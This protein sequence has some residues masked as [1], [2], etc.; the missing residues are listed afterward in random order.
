[1]AS[2]SHVTMRRE[3]TYTVFQIEGYLNQAMGEHLAGVIEALMG[4]GRNKFVMNLSKAR[5]VNSAGILALARIIHS[6]SEQGGQLHFCALTPT[7]ERSFKVTGI[8]QLARICPDE[9]S[10]IAHLER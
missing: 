7:V 4:R 9:E 5:L 2:S 1:M 8:T 10:A 3:A 6:L